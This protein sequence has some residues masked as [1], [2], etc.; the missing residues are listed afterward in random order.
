MAKVEAPG[1][2]LG[3]KDLSDIDPEITRALL[4]ADDLHIDQGEA[5]RFAA[6]QRPRKRKA[7]QAAEPAQ[8]EVQ[9]QEGK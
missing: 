6:A 1:E 7:I 8:A 2:L 4:N 3:V 5:A 9:V